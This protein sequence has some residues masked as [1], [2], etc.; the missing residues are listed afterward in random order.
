[1][2]PIPVV[3]VNGAQYGGAALGALLLAGICGSALISNGVHSVVDPEGFEQDLSQYRQTHLLAAREMVKQYDS[4][5][6]FQ[7][8][9]YPD[10]DRVDIYTDHTKVMAHQIH[11]QCRT[12]V[13]EPTVYW[14]VDHNCVDST[15]PDR[16]SK[17][18]PDYPG[19]KANPS[20][21]VK[22]QTPTLTSYRERLDEML[23]EL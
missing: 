21:L 6:Q 9:V 19:T 13:Y 3:I 5:G 8:Q 4:E 16:F 17:I 11:K 12:R 1:M 18:N 20:V 14:T 15:V 10:W 2:L 7:R 22:R 23:T